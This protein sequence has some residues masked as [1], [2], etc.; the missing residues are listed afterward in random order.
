VFFKAR[1]RSVFLFGGFCYNASMPIKIKQPENLFV[2]IDG[3]AII[4]RAYHAL[5][6]LTVKDGTI[7]NAVFGFTSMLLKVLSDLKPSH[8]A[9]SFDVAGGTFR[10]EIYDEYKATRAETDQA[11][12]DQVPLVY[13]VVDAFNI[14]IYEKEGYEADDVIGTLAEKMKDHK[15]ESRVVIVTGDKDMLQLVSD[16]HHVQVAMLTKGMSEFTLYDESVVKEKFGFGPEF[17]PDFKGLMGDSSDNIPGVKGVG[18]K[19]AT[20]LIQTIGGVEKI[21][22][23]LKKK[24][25][26]NIKPSVVAKLEN[27]K[28]DARMSLELAQIVTDVKGLD[29]NVG[30][31]KAHDFDIKQVESLF[32]KFEF[33]SLIKRIP[34][35]KSSE[36]TK[37]KKRD[38]SH[39][40]VVID[41]STIDA[42]LKT[43][44]KETHVFV[45]PVEEADAIT[46]G[47]GGVVCATEKACWYIQKQQISEKAWTAFLKQINNESTMLV[48]HDLKR[49]VKGV[50]TEGHTQKA[51]LFDLMI[52]SYVVNSSSRA[53]DAR[54]I[55]LRERGEDVALP[56]T[57]ST[58]FG[59]DY[60]ALSAQ[61][62]HY[63]A[64][65]E[66]YKTRLK[67]QEN[68]GL[69]E[70]VEMALIP[71]LARM[72]LHG[73]SINVDFLADMSKEVVKSIEALTKKIHTEA[74]QEFN[75]AS[76]V[77]LRDILFDVLDLPTQGIKKGKT[78]YS[79]AASE[80]EKLH[81]IHPIISHIEE[82]RELAKL[83]NTYIDVLPTLVHKKTHRIHTSFNQAVAATGRLSSS[84][85]NL[86]NIPIRTPLGRR[87]REAFV[88]AP[89][90][91]LVAADYSQIELRIVASLAQDKDM[92]EI[93]KN[94]DDIHT[95]TAAAMNDVP[96]SKV[97]KEMRRAAKEVN[98]GVLYGMGAFGL[99]WRAGIP[100]WQAKEFI[101]KYF[102]EFSGVRKF[103]DDTLAFAKKN[104]YVETLFGR[105]RSIPELKSTNYQLRS[106]GERMAINMPVQGTAA[107][108][109]KMAM[110]ALDKK[111]E[112]L[113]KKKKDPIR[114][115]LQVHDELV[116]EV[117]KGMEKD[118][119]ALMKKEMES[120][121][122]LRVPVQVDVQHG[123]SW[124]R[125]K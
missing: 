30:D 95:A 10:D 112:T 110:I 105:R 44:K 16:K 46:D 45:E 20:D 121:V 5:P 35:H 106:A 51:T 3:H 74:G 119:A 60:M 73:I 97:T 120:V 36:K 7:V 104:G 6:P 63:P 102:K 40:I 12:F 56:A 32:K 9:V 11:L 71:V 54:S 57:Q 52:A 75:V 89:G 92:L 83:Q 88:A 122:T 86:Q 107:D 61:V 25:D 39:K 19:T 2:I 29:F 67:E 23:T 59:A 17:I 78:G 50:F 53:H 85:P 82:H 100:Q 24:K 22:E 49:Y 91:V 69:F 8:I 31:A 94:G 115:L 113:N 99:S 66:V 65:H 55:I 62:C 4:H 81:G 43:I 37:P 47:L 21:Y 87:V 64:L 90:H 27:G 41:D 76:S 124:G 96:L 98:F 109:M 1:A 72:E 34:G 33:F 118:V 116:V 103:L 42:C 18:K 79:T 111:I 123:K 84:S 58:L 26:I 101:E 48:G 14:P 108:L 38:T 125:L 68:L 114:M 80:L 15:K 13:D 117:K 93:F 70:K 77:Q 28:E